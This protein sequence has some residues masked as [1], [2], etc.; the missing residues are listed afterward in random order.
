VTRPLSSAARGSVE[1]ALAALRRG[2]VVA[3]ATDTV[4]GLVC[5]P[6]D[7][8]A[9]DRV[10]ALKRRPAELELTLLAAAITDLEDL[11]R[12]NESARR[13][14]AAFWP[15]PL[16]L[17]LPRTEA[18]RAWELGER[19]GTVGVRVPDHPIAR[20]VLAASGPVAATS[21]NVSGLPPLTDGA[22]L[23]E[24]FGDAVDVYLTVPAADP[25][26]RG[27]SP[28]AASTVVDLTGHEP[29]VLREG[30]VTAEQLRTALR[31]TGEGG[32]SVPP[33]GTR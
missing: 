2:E 32:G 15:G 24:A 4:Y 28:N 11:V 10:F 22:A 31:T 16:T 3:V 8:N 29:R 30:P 23:V 26:V 17:I 21:A 20:A 14:A 6:A 18:S 19:S 1:A 13:L 9:V 5:D 7:P 25:M 27:A 12:W 33:G